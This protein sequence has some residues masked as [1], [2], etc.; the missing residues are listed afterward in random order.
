MGTANLDRMDVELK[1]VGG[2]TAL[3]EVEGLRFLTD[4]TFDSAPAAYPYPAGVLHKTI[5][6]AVT[7]ESLGSIDAV[8]LSHDHHPDNLDNAGREFLKRAEMVIT[9]VTG[10]ERLGGNSFGL[11]AWQSME[12]KAADG[13]TV[14]VTATP[15]RHG[16]AHLDRGP[17]IGFVLTALNQPENSIYF[18]GDTVWYEGVEELGSRFHIRTALL[19]LGA[20]RV[21]A[22]GPFHL[23][24]TADEAV[25][26]ARAFPDATVVP[27]HFEGW[28]HFSEGRADIERAFSSAGLQ[29]RLKWIG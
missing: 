23:T 24:M 20:A 8:L 9:T 3:I 11:D 19:N 6:P 25:R 18:S 27:L 14:R 10:G 16:P 21:E 4:P 1:Y 12:M 7:P 28:Q 15:A 17:V 13:R 26:F 22:V 2:P 29:S 5:G